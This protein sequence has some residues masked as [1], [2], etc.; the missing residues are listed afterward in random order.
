MV[1]LEG[2]VSRLEGRFDSLATKADLE[3]LGSELRREMGEYAWLR[4][5]K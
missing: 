3:R 2:R 5:E 4:W 1:T